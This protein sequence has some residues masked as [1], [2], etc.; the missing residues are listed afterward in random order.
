[1]VQAD[2]VFHIQRCL[3]Q[4]FFHAIIPFFFQERSPPSQRFILPC[5]HTKQSKALRNFIVADLY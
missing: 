1:V 3:L 2:E 5:L 4:N